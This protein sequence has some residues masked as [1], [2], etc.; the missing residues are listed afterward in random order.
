MQK[1]VSV[2]VYSE[3]QASENS[4]ACEQKVFITLCVF[5]SKLCRQEQVRQE[6][7][8]LISVSPLRVCSPLSVILSSVF[9]PFTTSPPP[10]PHLYIWRYVAGDVSCF[11]NLLSAHLY[12]SHTL[13]KT[14]VPSSH[15]HLQGH[16]CRAEAVG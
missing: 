9:S 2:F 16:V 15:T 7:L 12:C 1:C 8:N 13:I 4:A 10:S 11:S 3:T 14:S 6:K 5:F